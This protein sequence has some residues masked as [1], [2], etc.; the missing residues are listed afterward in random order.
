MMMMMTIS[1]YVDAPRNLQIIPRQS[2]Y[3]AEDRIKCSAEGNPKPSYHWTDL[4]SGT[5]TKGAFL[6]IGEE[7][8]D[9]NHTFQCTASNQY[10]NMSSN[11][12]FA[13]EGINI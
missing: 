2:T 13:V 1:Y 10:N 4:V 9:S 5:V 11:L 6:T 3:E 7:M 12:T 8:V